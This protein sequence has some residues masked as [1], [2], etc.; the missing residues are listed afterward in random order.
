MPKDADRTGSD[1]GAIPPIWGDSAKIWPP[2]KR[3]AFSRAYQDES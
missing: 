2:R 1:C 3:L